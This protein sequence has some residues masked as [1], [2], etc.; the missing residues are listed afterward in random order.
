LEE[1]NE[2]PDAVIFMECHRVDGGAVKYVEGNLPKK[3]NTKY[4][5][6]DEEKGV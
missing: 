6:L 5:I 4:Y 1:T 2:G 3:V